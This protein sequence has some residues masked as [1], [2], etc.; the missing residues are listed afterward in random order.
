MFGY[1]SFGGEELGFVLDLDLVFVYD[2]CCVVVM[3][4]GVCLLEGLCWY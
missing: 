2:S 3:S 1:G 4:D